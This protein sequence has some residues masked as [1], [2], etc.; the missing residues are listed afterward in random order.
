[1]QDDGYV[2]KILVSAGTK[3]IKVNTVVGIIVEEKDDV[4]LPDQLCQLM[5]LTACIW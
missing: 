4:R 3:D 2:A 1:L 5:Q